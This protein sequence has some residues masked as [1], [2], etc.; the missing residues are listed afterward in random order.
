MKSKLFKFTLSI[1]VIISIGLIINSFANTYSL[2]NDVSSSSLDTEN[3]S[4]NNSADYQL[5]KFKKEEYEKNISTFEK[6]SANKF[7]KIITDSEEKYFYFGR[8]SCPYCRAFVP[9]LSKI[10]KQNNVTIYYIDTEDTEKNT[11]LKALRN[12][13]NID[14]VPSLV[15]ISDNG[16][17]VNTYDSETDSL[18]QFLNSK[19]SE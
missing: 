8:Q 15:K 16:H 4:K 17:T 13:L 9:S 11:G 1:L 7:K 14:K 10:S 19:K 3:L 5:K 18:D 6:I 12:E 2:N